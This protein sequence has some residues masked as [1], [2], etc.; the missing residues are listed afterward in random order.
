MG[1]VHP[2]KTAT[3]DVPAR[4]NV[5]TKGHVREVDEYRET[6]FG[7]YM[8]RAMVARPTAHW[9]Q[10]WLLPDLG[11]AVTDWW[12]N[13][14][15]ERDQDFYLDV[16][17]VV[18]DGHRWLLTD[19][20]LDIVVRTGLDST[21]IDVDE[22]VGAVACGVLDPGAAETAMH[23]THRAVDGLAA[24]GHDLDAWLGSLG[25]VLTW[26]ERPGP[27]WRGVS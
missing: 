15:H 13:P 16:C 3:F 11:L 17:D 4:L 7:L 20:Y 26:R 9:M 25:V 18:R 21:V 8:S 23:R 12:W 10:T 2:P 1:P 27:G 14:G 19:H 5:D 24:H 22:F 6:P